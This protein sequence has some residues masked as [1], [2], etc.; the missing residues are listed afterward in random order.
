MPFLPF[1]LCYSHDLY[2]LDKLF[3][4]YVFLCRIINGHILE[5]LG[6]L[7][8]I[9]DEMLLEYYRRRPQL[10]PSPIVLPFD[11]CGKGASAC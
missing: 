5:K 3:G 6:L 9:E 11:F 2:I 8:V 7:K 1:L 4:G 10:W